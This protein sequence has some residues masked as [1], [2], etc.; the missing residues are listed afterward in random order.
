MRMATR[1]QPVVR[2]N[3]RGVLFQ[4]IV[5]PILDSHSSLIAGCAKCKERR[6]K[7]DQKAPSCLNC[8]SRHL[9]CPGYEKRYHWKGKHQ[10]SHQNNIGSTNVSLSSPFTRPPIATTT[11]PE[12][13]LLQTTYRS[14]QGNI[15]GNECR[16][17]HNGCGKEY[18]DQVT[19]YL[20]E[21]THSPDQGPLVIS[22]LPAAEADKENVSIFR[23]GDTANTLTFT[24]AS[25]PPFRPFPAMHDATTE[26][27][28]H[29]FNSVC[30]INSC[31]ASHVDPLRIV[32]QNLMSCSRLIHF[33][34]LSMSA[35]HLHHINPQW[36][37]KSLEYLTKAISTLRVQLQDIFDETS[38]RTPTEHKLDQALVGIIILGM[39]TSWHG[40]S[41]LGLEHI[42][43][44]RALLQKYFLPKLYDGNAL[45]RKKLS[46]F[47]GLQTYW[48]AV[49]SF[50]LDQEPDELE[51]LYGA[52]IELSTDSI[53]VH[54]WT[55]INSTIWVLLAKAGCV[56]RRR[57]RLLGGKACSVTDG[58]ANISLE[59]DRLVQ[60]AKIIE[61]QLLS[62]ELPPS[63]K[64]DGTDTEHASIT[65]LE[66]IARS[67]KFAA[68]LELYRAFGSAL[69]YRSTL[70][71]LAAEWRLSR[72][73]AEPQHQFSNAAIHEFLSLSV[74]NTLRSISENSSTRCL[75]PILLLI[76]GSTLSE[77]T[78]GSNLDIGTLPLRILHAPGANE[79]NPDVEMADL[80]F[81]TIP[82]S[83]PSI[84]GSAVRPHDSSL[85]RFDTMQSWRQFV[86]GRITRLEQEI[87]LDSIRRIRMVL[88]EVWAYNDTRQ[89]TIPSTTEGAIAQVGHWI[90]IME[91]EKLQFLF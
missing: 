3:S 42:A 49:A 2:Q 61:T 5:T 65:D 48:E 43:G 46:F 88:L 80:G 17:H 79:G 40:S 8:T 15:L 91:E 53:Y 31:S 55:G 50:L 20:D 4:M 77:K 30:I 67:C 74:L 39:S 57:R 1:W 83:Y 26:L 64:V 29:Y 27:I 60:Q 12:C 66:R 86:Y 16:A 90:D 51:Y 6:I 11:G 24:W 25:S 84:F 32:T 72:D 36:A 13:T 44:S 62:H 23:A 28:S 59:M 47:L 75:Q 58:Q 71:V 87:K 82:Q 34:V 14:G 56:A 33:C 63:P 52:C 37:V 19:A 38:I 81:N 85:F 70:G 41:G 35:A 9:T 69:D 22:A 73:L 10:I 54:P 18:S 45:D 7:C 78:T 21:P 76:A 68:L 89:T